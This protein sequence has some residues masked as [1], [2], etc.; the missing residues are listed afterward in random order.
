MSWIFRKKND[1]GTPQ[2]T[3]ANLGSQSTMYYDTEKKRW[4]ERG[5]EHLEKEEEVLAPPPVAKKEEEQPSE[6]AASEGPP[7]PPGGAGPKKEVNAVDAMMA[8]P[9]PYA[10]ILRKRDGGAPKPPVAAVGAFGSFPQSGDG[11]G[12]AEGEDNSTAS[13]PFA[14]KAMVT[15]NPFAPKGFGGVVEQP[16]NPNA[17]RA[18]RAGFGG[19]GAAEPANPNAP[20]SF[21]DGGRKPP[22]KPSRASPFATGP[23]GAIPPPEMGDPEGG[24]GDTVASR[25]QLN[26]SDAVT[27]SGG[28]GTTQQPELAATGEA[29]KP[30]NPP[31]SDV[32]EVSAEH[33]DCEG[34]AEVS[35]EAAAPVPTG[36]QSSPFGVAPAAPPVNPNAPRMF[37]ASGDAGMVPPSLRTRA[38]PFGG[39][40]QTGGASEDKAGY[41]PGNEIGADGTGDFGTEA[42]LAETSS[43][44]ASRQI[45][46]ADAAGEEAQDEQPEETLG[47]APALHADMPNAWGLQEPGSRIEVEE[48]EVFADAETTSEPEGVAKQGGVVAETEEGEIEEE[49]DKEE[50]E[51]EEAMCVEADHVLET[52]NKEASLQEE[53]A[54]VDEQPVVMEAPVAAEMQAET[55]QMMTD[56]AAAQEIFFADEP[57]AAMASSW[58]DMDMDLGSNIMPDL[59]VGVASTA[60]E[61]TAEEPTARIATAAGA[62]SADDGWGNFDFDDFDDAPATV[63]ADPH[64]QGPLAASGTA[65]PA[66]GEEDEATPPSEA[67]KLGE[68][69]MAAALNGG[70]SGSGNGESTSSW[71]MLPEG[72]RG[73][74]PAPPSPE[75]SGSPPT[76][77]AAGPPESAAAAESVDAE[78]AAGQAGEAA[79][80]RQ[81][82]EKEFM[83]G[84]AAD[85]AVAEVGAVPMVPEAEE[86]LAAEGAAA[87]QEA[88]VP[89]DPGD[90]PAVAP[91][92]E[93]L[94]VPAAAD[95]AAVEEVTS[96]AADVPVATNGLGSFEQVPDVA[97]SA[98]LQG[99]LGQLREE[100]ARL[101]EQLD[102]SRQLVSSQE[103]AIV[104]LRAS[105]AN[106]ERELQEV[107]NT[108]AAREKELIAAC[109]AEAT[110]R[111]QVEGTALEE[112]ATQE[113]KRGA[114][115]GQL[116]A[117]ELRREEV[118]RRALALEER[119]TGLERQEAERAITE[120]AR[121][122]GSGGEGTLPAFVVAACDNAEVR[123][124]VENLVAENAALR[125]RVSS[126][127]D[128]VPAVPT[129]KADTADALGAEADIVGA[130]SLAGTVTEGDGHQIQ[131]LIAMLKE[132]ADDI[133]VCSQ[134]CAALETLTFTSAENRCAVVQQGG[135]EIILAM[136]QRHRD[137]D[138]ALLRRSIDALWNLT[139]DAE[140]VDHVAQAG[141]V[142]QVIELMKLHGG[143]AD[144]QGGA[145]GVLLNLA[146][147]EHNRWRIA[148][149]GGLALVVAAMQQHAQSE[150]VLE[151]GCQALYMLAYH[152]DLRP[153]VLA[154]QA[155]EVAA[156]AASRRGRAQKWGRWL[157]EVLAC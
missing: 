41:V 87:E 116:E 89:E 118:E 19:D 106:L 63:A 98:A 62:A 93:D 13:N 49:E 18:A 40:L 97:V 100:T 57:Q 85:A 127:G 61:A 34:S 37:R 153:L 14:P 145:C 43:A 53:E 10:N 90:V 24:D 28:L 16:K 149:G 108:A 55:A 133:Q 138:P 119:L 51:E 21:R 107:R 157:Q 4:R 78:D 29:S 104:E 8:P 95:A 122:G 124:F 67:S 64:E 147:K 54:L 3:K 136:M 22:A 130:L 156:S 102:A 110:R 148:R 11:G 114:L 113:E 121:V 141:G 117:A 77:P 72:Q 154:A 96:T 42:A 132:H 80:A 109:E 135:I 88:A 70:Q 139:F 1:D 125:L 137:A 44:P 126:L 79:T 115:L 27:E 65:L 131:P 143:R 86:A 46:A 94:P 76:P 103:A 15:A 101:A 99:E 36:M 112:A 151:L 56:A 111:K 129:A 66:G 33:A 17:P 69:G 52:A 45:L 73:A 47:E 38:S 123:A 91:A 134:A 50:E 59:D 35:S 23:T 9:N 128:E 150:E 6:K 25:D 2:P 142:E 7:P 68:D 60:A 105:G 74:S 71:V 48:G 31:A 84:A 120:A 92:A 12:G 144:L 32:G 140:A 26:P 30:S 152:Q 39:S 58:G 82:D 83:N 81:E 146:A 75:S 5:K 20:R 155:G